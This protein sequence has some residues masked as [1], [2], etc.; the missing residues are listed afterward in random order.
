MNHLSLLAMSAIGTLSNIYTLYTTPE[1]FQFIGD[2]LSFL[3]LI[4]FSGLGIII[5]IK[6]NQSMEVTNEK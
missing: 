3:I 4:A 6:N 5:E 1:N 2:L